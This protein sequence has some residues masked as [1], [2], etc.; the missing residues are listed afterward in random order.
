[1]NMKTVV[2]RGYGKGIRS[3]TFFPDI[4]RREISL[5]SAWFSVGGAFLNTG[6]HIRKAMYEQSAPTRKKTK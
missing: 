2:L 1:M 3:L 4:P 5:G 6:N